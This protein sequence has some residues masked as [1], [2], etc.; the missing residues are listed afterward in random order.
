MKNSVS[1]EIIGT[2][3]L[4]LSVFF[5]IFT[6]SVVVFFV[7]FML[8][9][10]FLAFASHLELNESENIPITEE[11]LNKLSCVGREPDGTYSDRWDYV[12]K[13]I[14]NTDD[15]AFCFLDET[16]ERS[17]ILIKRV[18]TMTELRK[19]YEAVSDEPLV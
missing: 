10:L 14:K 7:V 6:K 11:E 19:I 15:W 5:L 1:C 13:P 2:I 4:V 3:I 12:I 16:G 8:G 9:T 18:K 17:D